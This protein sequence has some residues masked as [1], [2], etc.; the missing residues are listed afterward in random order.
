RGSVGPHDARVPRDCK[1]FIQGDSR[2]RPTAVVICART[3]NAPRIPTMLATRLP[4][5]TLSI[6]LADSPV[7]ADFVVKGATL[8]DGTSKA[9]ANGDLAIRGERIVGVGAFDVKGKPRILDGSGLVVAPGFIDLHTHSDVP[10]VEA[11]TRSNL[12]YL[13]Q[14]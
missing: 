12:N 4:A 11:A 3:P 2:H 1:R 13:L 10:I 7:E 6:P 14:G 5:L 9:G 8:Y